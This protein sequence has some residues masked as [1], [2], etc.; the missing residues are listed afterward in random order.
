MIHQI[1]LTTEQLTLIKESLESLD[2]GYYSDADIANI[3]HL[4]QYFALKIGT[5]TN[6]Q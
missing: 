3:Q 5:S 1:A 6:E 4:I 2:E